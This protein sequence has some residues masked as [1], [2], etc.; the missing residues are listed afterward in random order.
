MSAAKLVNVLGGVVLIM[1]AHERRFKS[2]GNGE[3]G[4]LILEI[5]EIEKAGGTLEYSAKLFEE[6]RP[7]RR[8]AGGIV[9]GADESEGYSFGGHVA[10]SNQPKLAGSVRYEK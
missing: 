6:S 2:N 8:I 3:V 5:K 4:A 10:R 7:A 1:R 9:D